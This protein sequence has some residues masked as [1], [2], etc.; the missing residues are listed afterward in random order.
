MLFTCKLVCRHWSTRHGIKVLGVQVTLPR[1]EPRWSLFRLTRP[2]GEPPSLWSLYVFLL[3]QLLFLRDD[4][5]V[6]SD[7]FSFL[8]RLPSQMVSPDTK[9][10]HLA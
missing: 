1:T 9:F 2:R 10:G 7:C 8:S 4:A 6:R 5:D 3:S